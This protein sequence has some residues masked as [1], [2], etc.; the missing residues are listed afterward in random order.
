MTTAAPPP[1]HRVGATEHGMLRFADGTVTVIADYK[2]IEDAP[3][4]YGRIYRTL[5]GWAIESPSGISFPSGPARLSLA[6]MR[7]QPLLCDT[8]VVCERKEI[9]AP[10]GSTWDHPGVL[11]AMT[12]LDRS[13]NP[14]WWPCLTRALHTIDNGVASLLEAARPVNDGGTLRLG[15]PADRTREFTA[16]G[17]ERAVVKALKK[18]NLYGAEALYGEANAIWAVVPGTVASAETA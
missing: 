2:I 8:E 15:L 14:V 18:C 12:W 5:R 1:D 11:L 4:A 13:V 9:A 6:D 17:G 16:L 10:D 3:D 7:G